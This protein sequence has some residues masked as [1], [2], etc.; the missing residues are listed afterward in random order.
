MQ[1]HYD[2]LTYRAARTSIDAFGCDATEAVAF[3]R[4]SRRVSTGSKVLYTAA[5]VIAL[6]TAALVI[7]G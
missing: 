1:R 6:A 5:A 7:F 4:P 2:P 3:H